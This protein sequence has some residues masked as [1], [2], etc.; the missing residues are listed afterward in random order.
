[1]LANKRTSQRRNR[2]EVSGLD[3]ACEP[4]SGWPEPECGFGQRHRVV[5]D[6]K[7]NNDDHQ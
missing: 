6:L 3:I 2:Q 7:E 4:I 5:V 1:M